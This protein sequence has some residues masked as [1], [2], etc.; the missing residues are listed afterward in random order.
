MAEKRWEDFFPRLPN[1][2]HLALARTPFTG[3][4]RRILDV[5]FVATL[6]TP[7]EGRETWDYDGTLE[8]FGR[9]EAEKTC[10]SIAGSTGLH[11]ETVKRELRR[12]VAA[13]VVVRH[14]TGWKGT[15]SVLSVEMD[16]GR[17]RLDMLTAPARFGSREAS[18]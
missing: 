13:G 6:G 14:L 17:W 16:P 1:G 3:A 5:L 7:G 10:G 18:E 2:F 8:R 11:R 4:Q 15:P 12:L 9:E